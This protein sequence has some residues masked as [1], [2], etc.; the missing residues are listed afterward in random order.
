MTKINLD[1]IAGEL[2]EHEITFRGRV[3]TAPAD[4]SVPQMLALQDVAAAGVDFKSDP[5]GGMRKI[6]DLLKLFFG[7]EQ[8]EELFGL[9][10]I[11]SLSALLQAIIDL[12]DLGEGGKAPGSSRASRRAGARSKPTSNGSTRSTSAK[13]AS[14]R[15]KSAAR[16]SRG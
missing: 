8:G 7:D 3:F 16:A 14:A 13:P 2:A 5:D 12:Y 6:G 11:R 4:L 15:T 9:C 1:D 10:G